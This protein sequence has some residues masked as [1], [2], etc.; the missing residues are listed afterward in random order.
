MGR[1]ARLIELVIVMTVGVLVV[2]GACAACYLLV[3]R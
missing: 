3:G 2:A 1:T